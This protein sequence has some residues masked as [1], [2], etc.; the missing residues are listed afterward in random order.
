MV[1]VLTYGMT[2]ARDRPA[3]VTVLVILHV[4]MGII[5]SFTGLLFVAYARPSSLSSLTSFAVSIVGGSSGY[6]FLVLGVGVLWFVFSV[7]SFVL[8]YALWTGQA[9]SWTTSL[10]LASNGLIIG[11]LGLLL[12]IFANALAL[13]VYVIILIYLFIPSV[14]VF[15]GRVHTY[16]VPYPP[17]LIAGVGPTIWAQSRSS[18]YARGQQPYPQVH[19]RYPQQTSF[20]LMGRLCPVCRTTSTYNSNFCDICGTR[21]T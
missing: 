1:N 7:F 17:Y 4:I 12:G 14:R 6:G 18:Q 9:W 20:G 16:P 10:V 21:L 5:A 3:A 11:G 13:A 19:Q 15:F 8:V 2:Y